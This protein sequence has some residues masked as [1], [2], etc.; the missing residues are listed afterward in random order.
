MTIQ[1]R[2]TFTPEFKLEAAQL[3]IQQNYSIREAAIAIPASKPCCI[4][5][6]CLALGLKGLP[7][8]V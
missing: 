5:S 7:F 3:V 6:F 8:A 1:R 2:K 4:M